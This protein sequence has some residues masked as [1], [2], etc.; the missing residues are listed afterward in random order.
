MHR[1]FS[2]HERSSGVLLHLSS[3]PGPFGVGD[4]GPEACAFADFLSHARQ[5]WWQMLPVSPEGPGDSPYHST[6]AS[7]G[8]PLFI[9]L[10]GLADCGLIDRKDAEHGHK[11]GVPGRADFG[12]AHHIKGRVFGKAFARFSAEGGAQR[13]GEFEGFCRANAEWLEEFALFAAIKR[14]H[15]GAPWSSW[16]EGLRKRRPEDLD[17]VR[18]SLAREIEFERFLQYEFD[19]QW[20]GLRAHAASKGVGLIG[21]VPIYV[22]HDS[23]D[24]WAHQDLFFLDGE[25]RSTVVAGVPPDYFSK[26]GQLWGNPL[27]RWDAHRGQGFSWWIS[28]L[29]KA[30][31]RF[32]V[33]R[34]DHFIGF[35]RYWEIPAGAETAVGGR[36][37][38]GPGEDIFRQAL[39][40]LKGGQLIAEDLGAVTD[41]VLRLRDTFGFPG[42]RVL[43]FGFGSDSRNVHLPHNFTPNSVVY[44]G[45][46]DNDTAAGW[47]FGDEAPAEAKHREEY[48]KERA[49]V[50]RY[51]NSDGW[52]VHWDLIRLA[53]ASIAKTAVFPAQDLLGLGDAARMNRPGKTEGNWLWRLEPGQLT[54]A[55]ANRLADLTSTYGRG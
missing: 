17:R 11:T 28:R 27:Y 10:D 7:A 36:W 2:L 26:T 55:I 45:T 20:R 35:Q 37:M 14:H 21:D 6:S 29:R 52:E 32:D 51:M 30:F 39:A 46:H 47:F 23:A 54:H 31:E 38:P 15:G 25:G 33:V 34:L 22:S 41:E 8:N 43:Q 49:F 9:G 16:E 3:L 18:G 50:L 4:L 53:M 5:R 19:R 40:V 42:M 12:H 13:S 48:K 24:V 1:H 44:T